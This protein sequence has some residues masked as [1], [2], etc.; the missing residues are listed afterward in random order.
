MAVLQHLQAVP[1]VTF[2]SFFDSIAVFGVLMRPGHHGNP[3]I[4]DKHVEIRDHSN[5]S[6]ML[7]SSERQSCVV[8]PCRCLE[9]V[10]EQGCEAGKSR[11]PGTEDYLL[12]ERHVEPLC[13]IGCYGGRAG[14]TWAL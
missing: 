11:S 13:P 7:L 6:L 5:G 1:E 9:H 8:A 3:K 2:V 14:I 4:Q 10:E 12:V